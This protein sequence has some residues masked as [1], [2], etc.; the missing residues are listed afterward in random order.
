MKHQNLLIRR[1]CLASLLALC[2]QI[3]LSHA[4]DRSIRLI[5]PFPPGGSTDITA[6]L[7]A[8]PTFVLRRQVGFAAAIFA[9]L[10]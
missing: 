3:P 1:A 10:L 6:R 5:V 7:L 9:P 8:E 4:Q 2:V